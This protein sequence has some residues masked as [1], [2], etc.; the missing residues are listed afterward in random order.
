MADALHYT[1]TEL[2]PTRVIDMAT[3]TG[4]VVRALGREIAGLWSN[5]DSLAGE[6]LQAGERTHERLWQMPL[7]DDYR[8]NLRSDIADMKNVGNTDAGA[9]VAA[10]FLQEFV[11]SVP[12]AHIDIAGTARQLEASSHR[13]KLSTGYGVRLL[14]DYLEQLAK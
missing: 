1:V 10:L 12:W 5:S 13:P 3:L 8:A 9:I 14:V 2:H 6:L 7:Y 4:S 11:Q